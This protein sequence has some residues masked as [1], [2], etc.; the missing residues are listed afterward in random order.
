MVT[1][2]WEGRYRGSCEDGL[3]KSTSVTVSPEDLLSRTPEDSAANIAVFTMVRLRAC[4]TC[5]PVSSYWGMDQFH[6]DD[7]T[8]AFCS[9]DGVGLCTDQLTSV[10]VA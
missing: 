9:A 2:G 4:Q 1:L 6:T 8:F 5:K 10:H 3:I 7:L